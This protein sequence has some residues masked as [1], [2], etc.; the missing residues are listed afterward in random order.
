MMNIKVLRT[1]FRL[2]FSMENIETPLSEQWDKKLNQ[3]LDAVEVGDIK[4]HLTDYAVVLPQSNEEYHAW[5]NFEHLTLST[6]QY[7]GT[8]ELGGG[9]HTTYLDRN[10]VS[11]DFRV[12]RMTKARLIVLAEKLRDRNKE[13]E[14]E[15]NT[16]L[17]D[18]LFS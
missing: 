16:K 1:Y 5:V 7:R 10:L 13:S 4:P 11:K 6:G 9:R 15:Q 14:N 17:M 8:F 2:L 3:L 12:R 18:D